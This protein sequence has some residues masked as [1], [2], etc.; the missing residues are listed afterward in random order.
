[1]TISRFPTPA[2]GLLKETVRS[3][4]EARV[5]ISEIKHRAVGAGWT[6]AGVNKALRECGVRQRGE[7]DDSGAI[8]EELSVADEADRTFITTTTIQAAP[9]S[10]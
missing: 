10:S 1:M 3:L 2:D 9:L 5:D 8:R 6:A 7:R 4:L